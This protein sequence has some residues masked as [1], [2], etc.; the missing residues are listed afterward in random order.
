MGII[1]AL[2]YAIIVSI[3]KIVL[4]RSFADLNSSSAFFIETI[5]GILIWIPTSFA[6]GAKPSE[7]LSILPI[8]F[9]SAI[10]SEA[11]IFYIYT[12]GD[13]S[14][15]GTIFPSYSIFTIIF[16][17]VFLNEG[18]SYPQLIAI[19]ATILGV[20]II[21]FSKTSADKIER[22]FAPAIWA[23]SGALAVGISDTLS[24]GQINETS[25]YSFLV[26]L[27]ICQIPVS[28][29]FLTLEKTKIPFREI[30]FTKKY[31]YSVISAFLIAVAQLF[32]WLAFEGTLASIASPITS[33]NTAFT[34]IFAFFILKERI[35]ISRVL[36]I[37]LVILGIIIISLI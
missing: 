35:T 36:G 2:T 4:K 15:I 24:K 21:S 30:I 22:N 20:I 23:L 34:A 33:T 13:I 18:L 28:L 32:F 17:T 19:S 16:A 8:A 5:F 9:I 31:K 10:L 1:F 11:Y 26:A 7:I 14:V 12:K 25:A 27:A 6:L 29:G 3:G 37:F